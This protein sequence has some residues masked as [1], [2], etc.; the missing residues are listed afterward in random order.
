MNAAFLNDRRLK[1][2]KARRLTRKGLLYVLVYEE[3]NFYTFFFHLKMVYKKKGG[4]SK[5]YTFAK[6]FKQFKYRIQT[7]YP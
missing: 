4:I 3:K 7:V 5:V 2:M 6:C 1:G